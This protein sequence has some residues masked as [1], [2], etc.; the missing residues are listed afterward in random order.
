MKKSLVILLVLSQIIPLCFANDMIQLDK[1][2]EFDVD[3]KEQVQTLKGSLFIDDTLDA[4]N[5]INESQKADMED[6]ENLWKAT[7]S[8]N[9]M[10]N[11]C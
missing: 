8:N 2:E 1:V 10:S 6:I 5:Q 4:Q 3:Y 11:F 7:V 9:P